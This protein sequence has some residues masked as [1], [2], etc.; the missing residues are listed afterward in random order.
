MPYL[1][2]GHN[3]IPKIGLRLD[4][5]DDEERLIILLQE[6]CRIRQA[7]ME[8]FFDGAPH[9]QALTQKEG[10]ITAHYVRKE[11]SAD[12]AIEI[13]LSHLGK[14]A[15]NWT[16]VSSDRRVQRSAGAVHASHITSEEFSRE[17]A[18]VKEKSTSEEKQG[19]TLVP[20]EVEEWLEIFSRKK[21]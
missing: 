7:R 19:A 8:I 1:V 17:V 16:V 6:F 21:E 2:D 15:R 4:S 3:L 11:S 13:R 20:K 14:S 18:K 10:R 9:G 5:I 12:A